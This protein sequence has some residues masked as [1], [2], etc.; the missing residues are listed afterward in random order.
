MVSLP[1]VLAVESLLSVPAV[2]PALAPVD[3]VAA[4]LAALDVAT[5]AALVAATLVDLD[6]DFLLTTLAVDS[7]QWV[8]AV[9]S[10]LTTL[11]VDIR[12]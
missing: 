4:T 11:A 2:A 7:T 1:W 3:L 6:V 5:L 9:D 12:P 8:P 10:L